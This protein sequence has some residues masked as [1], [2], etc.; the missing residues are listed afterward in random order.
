VIVPKEKPM[1]MHIEE[2][3]EDKKEERS[4]NNRKRRREEEE[5]VPKPNKQQKTAETKHRKDPVTLKLIEACRVTD[6]EFKQWEA[7]SDREAILVMRGARAM[8][9]K[10]KA[11]NEE[12][13]KSLELAADFIESDDETDK[14]RMVQF[15]REMATPWL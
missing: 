15:L 3:E 12:M 10:W 6:E 5:T 1:P 8:Y 9:Q 4:P 13:R 14:D 7:G 2:E 11:D